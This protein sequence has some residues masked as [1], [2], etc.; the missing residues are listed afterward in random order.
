MEMYNNTQTT[1]GSVEN[2]RNEGGVWRRNIYLSVSTQL[3]LSVGL[4]PLT[5]SLVYLSVYVGRGGREGGDGK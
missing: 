4:Y 3:S 1:L 5:C 2:G